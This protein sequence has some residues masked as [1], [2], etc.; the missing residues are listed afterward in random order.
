MN[1]TLIPLPVLPRR[2]RELAGEATA[3]VPSYRYLYERVL[4]GIIP[5]EQRNGRW[6]VREQDA[7][8]LVK[9]HSGPGRRRQR[10]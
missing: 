8:A 1:T 9:E 3:E 6:Y 2:L 5:A 10:G 7:R 4:N